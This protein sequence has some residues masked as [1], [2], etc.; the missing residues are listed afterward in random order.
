M[1]IN[2][3]HPFQMNHY[4]LSYFLSLLFLFFVFCKS[5][6]IEYVYENRN[7]VLNEMEKR[8][9]IKEKLNIFFESGF[10]DENI[11]ISVDSREKYNDNVITDNVIGLAKHYSIKQPK[12]D[13]EITLP[14][15]VINFTSSKFKRLQIYLYK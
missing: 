15:A 10:K 8:F 11:R 3:S 14:D 9:D 1:K 12:K 7:I 2:N 13:I 5:Q 4:K 6:G